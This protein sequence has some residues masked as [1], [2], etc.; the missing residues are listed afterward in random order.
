MTG[1]DEGCLILVFHTTHETLRAEAAFKAARIRSRLVPKPRE[2]RDDCA[3]ALVLSRD[4]E[5]QIRSLLEAQGLAPRT[6]GTLGKDGEWIPK[7]SPSAPNSSVSP[8]SGSTSPS[9]SSWD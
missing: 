6:V 2:A 3:M 7:K 8:P 4:E 9:A 5:E 1:L